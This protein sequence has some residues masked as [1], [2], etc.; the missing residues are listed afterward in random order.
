MKFKGILALLLCTITVTGSLFAEQKSQHKIPESDIKATFIELGSVNCIPCRAMQPIMKEI[1]NEYGGQVTVVFFDVWTE[2]GQPYSEK[3]K[4][5]AI[6]TQVFLDKKGKEYFRHI[7]FFPKKEI[8][9]ILKRA[10][11]K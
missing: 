10:G 5:L 4:I 9:K 1:E 2:A 6:P 8:V 7:G 11:V 3:Y